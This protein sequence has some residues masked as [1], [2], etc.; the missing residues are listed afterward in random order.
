MHVD[1]H[2][3]AAVNNACG[4]N[5]LSG[6]EFKC[7]NN[8]LLIAYQN[9]NLEQ[10]LYAPACENGVAQISSIV[11]IR[12]FTKQIQRDVALKFNIVID[13]RDC[14][15]VVF[16]QA[17]LKFFLTADLKTRAERIHHR[18]ME[19]ASDT[20]LV[21]TLDE[22]QAQIKLRDDKDLHRTISPLQMATDAILV[23]NSH[24]DQF[25]TL[26]VMLQS[27]GRLYL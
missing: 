9:K 23:D 24:L 27:T 1:L 22:V 10:E 12:D 18:L 26:E 17:N 13:G 3:S 25:Q 21:P 20:S 19:V 8:Q 15:T 7:Q 11:C 14:G 5:I 6:F 4:Q 16:P 2:D